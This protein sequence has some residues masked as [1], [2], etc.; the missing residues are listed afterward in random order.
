MSKVDEFLESVKSSKFGHLAGD[1]WDDGSFRTVEDLK[2]LVRHYRS[3]ISST[4]GRE[5]LQLCDSSALSIIESLKTPIRKHTEEPWVVSM[6]DPVHDTDSH[7]RIIRGGETLKFVGN[8]D[9][10]EDAE[11]AVECVN[12]CVRMP[13]PEVMI[14]KMIEFVKEIPVLHV[15]HPVLPIHKLAEDVKGLVRELIVET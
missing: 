15:H 11:R 3:R 5:A 13:N 9:R 6:T 10:L 12:A 8:M 14:P 2:Q 4:E 7:S 1:F